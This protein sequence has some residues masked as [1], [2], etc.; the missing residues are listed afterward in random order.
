M[1]LLER[2]DGKNK[3]SKVRAR[4]IADTTKATLHGVIQENVEKGTTVYTDAWASYRS[5]DKD[6]VHGF[7]DHAE[8]Y[9]DG[10]VH[11]NGLEN[12]WALLKR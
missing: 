7:V 11:T 2:H 4:V 6:Y 9:V 10:A 8:K 3:C 5:L 12:Y 1:G